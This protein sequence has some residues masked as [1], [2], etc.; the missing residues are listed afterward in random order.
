MSVLLP[1]LVHVGELFNGKQVPLNHT[2]SNQVTTFD[3]VVNKLTISTHTL[4][5]AALSVGDSQ[6]K[7]IPL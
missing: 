7:Y 3:I 1:V 5:E 6:Q 2:I 4:T